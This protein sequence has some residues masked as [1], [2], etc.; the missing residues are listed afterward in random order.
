MNEADGRLTNRV[1]AAGTSRFSWTPGNQL[2]SEDGPW[3]DDT[4]SYSHTNALRQSL[5]LLQ[6]SASAWS[7][8]YTYDAAK[9][10]KTLAS[11]AGTFSYNYHAGVDGVTAATRL[12]AGLN[13][14]N[15]SKRCQKVSKGKKGNKRCQ[16]GQKVSGTNGVVHGNSAFWRT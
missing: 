4:V 8:A 3:A 1:D 6:P 2:L 5:A 14:P 11:P 16:G 15:T 9:R 13:L 12:V 7:Q 10:L